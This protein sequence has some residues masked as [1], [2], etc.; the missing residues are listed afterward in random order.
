M[1]RSDELADGIRSAL[2]LEG[3]AVSAQTA[4][5]AAEVLRRADSRRRLGADHTVVAFAGSTGSG[6]SSLFNAVSGLEIA[7]VGVRR[8]T[9]S[10]PLACVWGEGGDDLLDWLDV[11]EDRRTWRESALD[12]DDEQ[13]LHGLILI[14]LPDHDSTAYGH[15]E[16]SDRLINMVDVVFWVVDP[17]KYADFSLHNRYLS[18][19]SAVAESTVVV[20]NQVDKLDAV[21]KKATL[22]HLRS[23]LEADGMERAQV[24]AASA[25]TREGVPELRRTLKSMIESREAGAKR[26]EQDL[27]DIAGR[28]RAE[29][30]R[31]VED[32]QQIP[33]SEILTDAMNDAIGTKAIAKTVHD[34]YMRRAY[35]TTAYPLM[36]K[37]SRGKADPLGSRH[38]GDRE[39]LL[40][41]AKP[42]LTQP[43][44]ARINLA[45]H[46]VISAASRRLP[47]AWKSA[48]AA[49]EEQ[50]A[51]RISAD[52]ESAV[53]G[54]RIDERRPGWWGAA[55]F[56]QW[57]FFILTILG[58][59]TTAAAAV[60]IFAFPEVLYGLLPGMRRSVIGLIALA[61]L[62][63]GIIGSIITS[64]LAAGARRKGADEAAREVEEDLDRAVHSAAADNVFEPVTELL[65]EHK[66]AYEAL[67]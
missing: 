42:E 15:R 10:E 45:A 9:T 35:S 60:L 24:A 59:I 12:G 34:D 16:V 20:L 1:N 26:I 33:Q 14:D 6:K 36:A 52:L 5:D 8:P 21:Q 48:A 31:P 39:V 19:M 11:P 47:T 66:K 63:I 29:L 44:T 50:S 41:A 64:S 55:S 13:P 3:G 56:F 38:G 2:D 18:K 25:V 32:P 61:P 67:S 27:T 30:G 57:L 43:Q 49:A 22:G 51:A 62:V 54:V 40:R 7:D 23:L 46:E 28:I 65:A 53:A 58:I 37:A 4:Q 17:Q